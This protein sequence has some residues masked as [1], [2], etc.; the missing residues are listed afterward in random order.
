MSDLYS[1]LGVK[2]GAS[3]AEIKSAYRKLAKEL[4]PDRNKDNPKASEK[5]SEL[6]AAYDLLSDKDKR[7]QYDRGDID[8][9][10]N[11]KMPFGYGGGQGRARPGGGMGAEDFTFTGAA[12]DIFSE[13]FG[14]GRRGGG[15]G[16]FGGFDF[17]G[18]S[19]PRQPPAKGRNV[20]YKL[21][22]DFAEAAELKP[23]RVTLASGKTVD[24]KLPAGFV[25]GQ[26][27]RLAGQGEAGPGGNGDAIVTLRVSPHR[28]FKRDGDDIRLELPIRL[29]EAVLGAKVKVPTA[30]GSVML[31]V[32]PGSSSGK[33]LRLKGKG[34]HRK[35]GGR[36]DLLVTLAID[37]PEDDGAL[38]AFA[39]GWDSGKAH[40]PRAGMA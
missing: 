22:V 10:G 24:L 11:P 38:K 9:Q 31:S 40:D 17:G 7:A 32:P 29:D 19:G 37:I 21:A 13:L 36:G 3:D 27:I 35:D 26:Q 6:T 2:R 20:A 33:V 1:T 23:Q 16:G 5:F 25:E 30:S 15:G 39:E 34:F 8:E 12:D 14:R 18:G 28:F 4:H